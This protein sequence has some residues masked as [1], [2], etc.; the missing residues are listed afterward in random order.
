MPIVDR[1]EMRIRDAELEK[2]MSDLGHLLGDK[3]PPGWGFCLQLFTFGEHGSNFYICNAQRK[4]MLNMMKEF[5]REHGETS[6]E[7]TP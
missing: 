3:C 4:D 1:S 6:L 2:L 7:P 5:L